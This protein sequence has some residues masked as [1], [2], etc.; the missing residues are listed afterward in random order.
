MVAIMKNLN[1]MC[2]I[3]LLPAA[4]HFGIWWLPLIGFGITITVRVVLIVLSPL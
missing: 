2:L 3:G 1:Y 4:I